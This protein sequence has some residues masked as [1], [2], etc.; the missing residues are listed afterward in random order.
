[1]HG[2]RCRALGV[3]IMAD[4]PLARLF[5]PVLDRLHYWL[6]QARLWMVGAACDP[7]L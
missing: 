2:A 1:M 5:W 4:R 6:M 3:A 7:E